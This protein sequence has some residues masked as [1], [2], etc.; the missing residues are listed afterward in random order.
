MS[1]KDSQSNTEVDWFLQTKK[2]EVRPV[3]PSPESEVYKRHE[4]RGTAIIFNHKNF[5]MK[6]CSV[7]QGTDKD[8]DD[9]TRLL[10]ELEFDV[11]VHNDL[12]LIQII[13]VLEAV[14]KMDHS[15]SDCL[16]V[17][18]MSHGENGIVCA[19][20]STYKT[21]ILWNLFSPVHCPSLAGKPKLFFIQACRGNHTDPG[22]EVSYEE[23]D[24]ARKDN[25][26]SIPIMADILVMYATVEGYF[27]WRDPE[28]GSFFIQALVH[29]LRNF[30]KTRD[31]LSILTC[32]NR[33]VAIGF[34]SNERG[35]PELDKK[36]E[37]CSIV[38]M[39]TR[40]FY[41]D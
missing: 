26:Y 32:V 25:I 22:F 35:V 16:V 40:L 3:A 15:N 29:Q 23:T 24:S 28:T 33:Q 6:E 19:K 18:V 41:L 21:N 4:R 17:A 14:S 31:L 37:M 12:T 2:K 30:H 13:E 7:R 36:K 8:R 9:L 10:D 11:F 20:D 34:T 39:L 27:A 38:S 5:T 1:D